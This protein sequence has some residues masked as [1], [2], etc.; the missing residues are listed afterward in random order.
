LYE[1]E[2]RS[3]KLGIILYFFLGIFGLFVLNKLIL[4]FCWTFFLSF[5]NTITN[6][7]IKVYFEAKI[8]EYVNFY[9]I[10]YSICNISCQFFLLIYFFIDNLYNKIHFI[11]NSRKIFY[12][13]FF[14]IATFITP[15]DI[16]SQLI[17]G[18]S[19]IILYE[20][21]LIIIFLKTAFN[22]VID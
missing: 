12:F 19:F 3:L 11:I 22:Y 1:F 9:I 16:F 8:T 14:V 6:Q 20:L 21:I 18:S 2:Y 15:P 17:T 7:A 13:T 4:P 10:L 5:Q